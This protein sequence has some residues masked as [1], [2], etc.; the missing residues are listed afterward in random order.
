MSDGEHNWNFGGMVSAEAVA[1]SNIRCKF[2]E[3]QRVYENGCEAV[4]TT[5]VEVIELAREAIETK[6]RSVTMCSRQT[7]L[8]AELVEIRA[9]RRTMS[10]QITATGERVK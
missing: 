2:R 4:P 9:D 10:G 7:N 3:V 5:T 1:T 6:R 8:G